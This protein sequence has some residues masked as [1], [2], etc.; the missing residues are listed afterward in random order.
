MLQEKAWTDENDIICW[1]LD[2]SKGRSVKGLNLLNA[3]Y[4]SGGVSIPVA[5]EIVKKPVQ[6]CDVATRQIK[7]ASEVTKNEQMR[8]M[9]QS[10]VINQLKFR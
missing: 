4:H 8:A 10:C 6:F 5:F 1:H 7:R 3:L 2:H 9:I